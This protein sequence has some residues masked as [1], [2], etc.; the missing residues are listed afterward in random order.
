MVAGVSTLSHVPTVTDCGDAVAA[1]AHVVTCG[2]QRIVLADHPTCRR[3]TFAECVES[4]ARLYTCLFGDGALRRLDLRVAT[5]RSDRGDLERQDNSGSQSL[6]RLS[7]INRS[8]FGIRLVRG[9]ATVVWL[10]R[11]LHR[12]ARYLLYDSDGPCAG[13]GAV[14]VADDL[15]NQKA[16]GKTQKAE[17]N[18]RGL[19]CSVPTAHCQLL[20]VPFRSL[21]LPL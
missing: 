15:K 7:E 21:A 12:N 17:T 8:N 14:S 10:F 9:G 13:G 20:Y 4:Y 18:N 6:A 19:H 11:Q 1:F 16:V 5:D 3:G 2:R